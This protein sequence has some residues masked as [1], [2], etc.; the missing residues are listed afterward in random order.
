MA[1]LILP[2]TR[3]GNPDEPIAQN[4]SS[5][6]KNKKIIKNVSKMIFEK[7][8]LQL[9]LFLYKET[10]CTKKFKFSSRGKKFKK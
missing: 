6:L 9:L 10:F 3:I 2:G 4:K 1:S 8:F 7:F 5:F